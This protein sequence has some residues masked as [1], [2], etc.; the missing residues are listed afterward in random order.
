MIANVAMGLLGVAGLCFGF[1]LVRGPSLADRLLGLDGLLLCV[2]GGI[3]VALARG[4][5]VENLAVMVLVAVVAF[6]A[7]ALAARFIERRG[8]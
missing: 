6:V 3:G 7:T 4:D 8:V 2:V 5:S 1:R